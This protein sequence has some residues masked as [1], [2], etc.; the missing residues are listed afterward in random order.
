MAQS[1]FTHLCRERRLEHKYHA[2]S[3]ATSREEIG[4]PPD[5]RTKAVLARHGIDTVPHRARQMT[6]DDYTSYDLVIIM[7]QENLR[8]VMRITGEDAAGKLRKLLSFC[9]GEENADIQ[10]PWYTHD[11]ERC[12][13]DIMR[14][15]EG[16][17]DHTEMAEG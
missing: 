11:F 8:G 15:C 12:F 3:A 6:V 2:D 17:L 13:T 14:G 16:L 7:D 4:N 5:P 10:D 9:P 1:I